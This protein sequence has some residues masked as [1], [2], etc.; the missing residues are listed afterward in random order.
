[1]MQQM[2]GAAL[3]ITV[4][5]IALASVLAF[6]Y[7]QVI[8]SDSKITAAALAKQKAHAAAEAGIWR[9]IYELDAPHPTNPWPT[10]GTRTAFEFNG[11]EILVIA[12]DLSGLVDLN[13]AP[14]K[15]LST[16]IDYIADDP[17][18]AEQIVDAIMDWRDRDHTV[19]E[20]GAE[21]V[22]YLAAGLDYG[23]KDGPFNTRE[24]LELVLG[25][26]S[27]EYKNIAPF[28]TVFSQKSQVNLTVAPAH[29]RNAMIE[30]KTVG[31]EASSFRRATD[32][33]P[34]RRSSVRRRRATY[35]IFVEANVNGV[36]SRLVATVEIGQARQSGPKVTILS[37]R[38]T[39]HFAIPTKDIDENPPAG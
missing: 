14:R 26:T 23:A 13:A 7:S 21:D 36:L 2:R 10:D 9:A 24:E 32:P 19:R 30:S 27:D 6:N 15:T 28:V 18:R 35:E 12:Q 22:D 4:W 29:V 20:F 39:W 16:I 33:T 37:W 38:E 25:L 3:V 31:A 17:L 34:A 1:M 11:A 8:R 5:L